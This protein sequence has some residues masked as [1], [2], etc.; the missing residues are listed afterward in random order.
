MNSSTAT[1]PTA[2]LHNLKHNKVLHERVVFLTV[3]T[4]DVPRIEE[5][6]ER[7]QIS[8]MGGGFWQV[9]AHYGFMES[10][11]MPTLLDQ[12]G[13]RGLAFEMMETSFFLGRE[14]IVVTGLPG[15]A[16]WRERLYSFM[17]RNAMKATEFFQIPPNRVVELGTQVEI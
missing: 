8:A 7:I 13:E 3:K 15:M 5:D 14:S 9:V 6:E 17:Q 10:A 16:V 11:H 2:M 1:V 12:C 4:H